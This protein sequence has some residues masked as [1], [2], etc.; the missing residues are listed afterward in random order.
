MKVYRLVL[1][2]CIGLLAV[3]LAIAA[4]ASAAPEFKPSTAQSFTGTSASG[5]LA[6]S[7]NETI[8]C[9]KDSSKGE[10]T[11]V[12]TVGKVT[13][14][15]TG[16]TGKKGEG[17]SCSVK[18]VGAANAGEIDTS[19]LKGELGTVA[20]AEATSEVGLDLEP[21]KQPFVNIEKATCTIGGAVEGS[22]AGEVTPTKVSQLTG[23]LVYL[24]SA[25]SQLIKKITVLSGSKSPALLAFGLVSSSEETTEEVT[26]TTAVEVT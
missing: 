19:S 26:Y 21:E 7:V 23:K 18:S 12:D 22:V 8:T 14:I 10:I 5:T 20:A 15:F 11:G 25:G 16:C 13:V 1:V 4:A 24:G 17:A 3:S 2:V 9:T 6:D